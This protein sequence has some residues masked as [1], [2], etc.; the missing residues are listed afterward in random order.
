VYRER[1][2]LGNNE[3]YNLYSSR[4]VIWVM[5]SR[6][7]RRAGHMAHMGDRLFKAHK[8]KT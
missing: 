7:M 3:I 6:G 1:R 2:R 4:N 8:K 5:K